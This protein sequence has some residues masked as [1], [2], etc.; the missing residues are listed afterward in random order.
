MQER[1]EVRGDGAEAMQE[2]GRRWG[3]GEVMGE[4]E[5]LPVSH[6][7]VSDKLWGGKTLLYI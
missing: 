2:G 4:G 5:K 1:G 3:R 6:A 7:F